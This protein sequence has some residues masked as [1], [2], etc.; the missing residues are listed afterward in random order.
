M[1][2]KCKIFPFINFSAL[3]G[4]H[5]ESF[6]QKLWNIYKSL[7]TEFL[8]FES[9]SL[10]KKPKNSGSTSITMFCHKYIV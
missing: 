1:V 4:T 9:R 3:N 6:Q 2:F 8:K 7:E 10:T 5:L